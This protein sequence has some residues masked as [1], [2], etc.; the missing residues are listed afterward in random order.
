[1]TQP[2]KRF[3]L[4]RRLYT[5]LGIEPFPAS[6]GGPDVSTTIQ[7]VTDADVLLRVPEFVG[8]EIDLTPTIGT[9]IGGLVVP[10]GKVWIVKGIYREPSTGVTQIRM[11]ADKLMNYSVLGTNEEFVSLTDIRLN[12]GFSIG[13]ITSGDAADGTIAIRAAIEEEDV[14]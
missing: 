4:W 9:F 11:L 13:L 8:V 1:V 5:R 10:E 12:E 14:F 7:P 6:G 3:D 2:A